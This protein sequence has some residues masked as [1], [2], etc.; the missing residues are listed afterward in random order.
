MTHKEKAVQLLNQQYH[1]S[2]AL[3]GAFAEDFGLDLKTAFKISTCF[4]GGMRQGGLCGCI[5]ASLLVLGMAFGFYDAQDR[6]LEAYGNQ[7]TEEFVRLFSERMQGVINCRDI[8]GKDISKPEDMAII[9]QDKLIL[10]KCPRAIDVS[11]DILEEQ[12]ADYL[13]D[14]PESH[15]SLEDIP[16]NDEMQTLLK[17]LSRLKRFRRNVNNL[18]L[19]AVKDVAFIQ[20]DIRK[21]KIVNDL[22]GEKFGD[23]VLVFIR[24]QLKEV[25]NDT[26]YYINLRSDVFMVVTEYEEQSEIIELIQKLDERINCFKDV[27]LQLTYGVYTVEDK[28]MELRQMEDRAAI[29]R[30]ASKNDV[31]TNILF[32]K[33]QFKES[34][35]NRKFIEEN[36]QAAI[37]EEQFMMYLQPKYSIAKNEIIGAEAL[38][39]WRHPK[40]GMIYP[41]QFIPII[42]ENGFIRKT[43]YYI[44]EKACRFIK[45]C[46]KARLR[47]CPL[48]VNVSR[49]HLRDN[50]CIQVLADMIVKYQ[51]PKSLLELEITESADNQQVSLKALQLKDEG[52]TLLM[53]D[54]GSG[55]SSLNV[56]LETPFDV[57]K[58]DKKF[59]ENMMVSNKGRLIL[60]QMV[61]MADKLQLGL[62]AE[63]V[64]TKEQIDLLQSIGC[65]QVQGYY[66]AKPMPEE[67]FYA[68]LE[69]SQRTKV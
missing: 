46:E 8:L 15:I 32:Y 28:S 14:T 30:K 23:E 34:L 41:D 10:K 40:R 56:L 67:D 54:F 4:G 62:L 29:A 60:E 2:Q 3:F 37:D 61:S 51:I 18:L 63:G 22:Y 52:F 17:D 68:L 55:Y 13:E 25:C 33:E 39:R 27:K 31:V 7:K 36:M 16:E 20:F 48:S 12:L 19:S 1:C 53:D 26:Q 45:K 24:K 11:I 66:Y 47:P 35:Y 59:M 50:E 21:F 49:V 38:I 9:R 5:S 43:D 44:W 6:E 69:E 58:L 42:E 65:D 64:E 57:I